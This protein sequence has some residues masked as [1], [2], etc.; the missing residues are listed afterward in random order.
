MEARHPTGFRV[1]LIE[2]GHIAQNML[3][4]ATAS[5][6]VATPTCALRWRSA[7]VRKPQQ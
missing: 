2:A 4:A 5:G 1:V 6:L 3:L 7:P